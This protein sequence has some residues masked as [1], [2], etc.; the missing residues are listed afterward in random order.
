MIRLKRGHDIFQI[1]GSSTNN[2]KFL[3]NTD[4]DESSLGLKMHNVIFLNSI[5]HSW[6]KLR[7]LCIYKVYLLMI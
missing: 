7:P 2:V 4:E 5:S 6:Q 1:V 3:V